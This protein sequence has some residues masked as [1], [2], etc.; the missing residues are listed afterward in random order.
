MDATTSA[1]MRLAE[2][3]FA[4][5]ERENRRRVAHAERRAAV[6]ELERR[7]TTRNSATDLALAGPSS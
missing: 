1:A 6:V 3:R 2:H 4:D 7:A 5:L